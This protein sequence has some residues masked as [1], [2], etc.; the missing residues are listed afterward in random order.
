LA[1]STSITSRAR[2]HFDTGKAA[3]SAE[4]KSQL[5]QTASQAEGT[6][7][8]LI[9]VVGYTDSTGSDDTNQALSEAG[10]QRYPL[11][12]AGLPLKPYRMLTPSGMAADPAA[13]ND[14]PEGKAQ[15]LPRFCEHSGQQ[16]G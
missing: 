13:S 14:T 7:N 5:C 9:L 3:L 2:V 16:G 1:I 15:N 8:A 11:P 4:D 10:K 6:E 12:A